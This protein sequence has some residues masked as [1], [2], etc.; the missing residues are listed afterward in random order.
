LL[1]AGYGSILPTPVQFRAAIIYLI[2]EQSM[3]QLP[4]LV[5]TVLTLIVLQSVC[6]ADDERE[7]K[8]RFKGVELYSWK[9]K[10]DCWVFV[11]LN[12]TN[13]LKT[14]EEVKGAKNQIKGAADLKKALARLAVGERVSWTHLIEGF[15]FPPEATRKEIE[16]AAEEA[17]IDLQTSARKK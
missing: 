2:K 6:R 4:Y 17:R 5:T 10:K 12:G 13:R 16:K 9:D 1:Q 14:E 15:E 7:E 3:K 11:L 8:P